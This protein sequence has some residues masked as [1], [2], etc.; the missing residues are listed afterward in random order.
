MRLTKQLLA[1]VAAAAVAGVAS[2]AHADEGMWTLDNFPSA[3]VKQTYGVN[4]DQAWLDRVRGAAARIPGCS[5]SVVSSDGLMLTNYHC[6][7]H[8]AQDLSTAQQDYLKAG[9]LTATREEEKRCAGMTAEI[10][11]G[12]TD[13]TAKVKAAGEGKSGSDLVQAISTATSAIEKENCD[14]QAG[15]RC[16]V[17]SFYGGGQYKLYKYRRYEDVRLVFAPEFKTGFFGGDPD[18]FNFPRFNLDIGFLRVYADGKPI[19]TPNHLKWNPAA[20]KA[21]EPIFV[22][23]N[24]GSTQRLLTVGQLETLRDF[25][26]PFSL[27]NTAEKR[28]RLI[29]FS[30]QSAENARVAQDPITFLENSHKVSWGK[31]KALSDKAFFGTK[32]REEQD[33][34]SKTADQKPWTDIE[35]AQAAYRDLY[36]PYYFLESNAGDASK[37]YGYAQT[38]VR[39][40]TERTKPAA[41]RLGGYDDA[42]LARMGRNLSAETPVQAGLEELYLSFWLSKAREHLTAD[43]AVTKLLLGRESPEAKAARLVAGSKL[44]D[45]AVRKALWEGGIDAVRASD[46]PL[47]QYVLSLDPAAREARAAWESRVTGPTAKAAAD[48][49]K[50]RFA[51]YGDAIYPDATFSLRLTYGSVKGWTERGQPIAPFTEIGGLYARNTGQA[52]Y[53]LPPSWLAAEAKIDKKVVFNFSGTGDI[54]GGASGSPT[55]NA[56][57]EVIGA[58]FDGNIHSLGGAYGYDPVLNRSVHVAASGVQEAL[59]KVYGRDALVKELNAK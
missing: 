22:A 34:R 30:Q 41:E 38:I 23:G 59:L 57:G 42:A 43:D 46:D 14:G 45:P 15:V 28:G 27:V 11:E 31:L 54:I 52:P 51:A 5:A 18:N 9:F 44:A 3:K 25:T 21:G 55:L 2:A 8:C 39:G 10:L 6:V 48:V 4:V 40:A 20:P 33:L 37:L 24:P 58:V 29:G 36:L 49:A 47:I 19:S 16:Q 56:K 12:I 26:L 1:T 53:D 32:Q 17:I 35:A 7:T 50:A 13:V